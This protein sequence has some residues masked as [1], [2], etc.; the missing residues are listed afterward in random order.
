[1]A[2][3]GKISLMLGVAA[4]ALT[5]LLFAPTKGKE[6]REKISKERQGGGLGH[7]AIAAELAKM[8]D[9]IAVMAQDVAK[10]E[11]AK[12]F[13]KKTTDT[14]DEISKGAVDLDAWVAEAHKKADLLKKAATKYADEKK[15][16]LK[17]A[18][19]VAKKTVKTAKKAVKK[20]KTTV[21][22]ATKIVKEELPKKKAPVKKAA[23]KKKKS[24]PKKK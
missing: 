12:Q 24:T 14:V 5:G 22:K 20:A 17:G 13:W 11:E 18:E 16:Y 7:K 19:T 2:N 3:K 6:L 15:K 8:A 23:P 9:E 21:K 4:G 10:S 1:M